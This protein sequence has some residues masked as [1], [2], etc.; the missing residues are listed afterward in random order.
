M[1]F[2]AV[3]YVLGHASGEGHVILK[4]DEDYEFLDPEN[5]GNIEI[6]KEDNNNNG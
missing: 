4:G 6:V 3:S 1:S 5:N 2:D